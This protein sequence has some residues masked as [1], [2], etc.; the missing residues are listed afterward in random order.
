MHKLLTDFVRARC[1][2]HP[3]AH[4]ALADFVRAFRATIPAS[5]LESWRRDR[6]I[7]NLRRGGFA[8]GI[9]DRV[10]YVGGLSLNHQWRE[11]GGQLVS[12][13]A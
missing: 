9:I 7:E 4:V 12:V 8:V 1:V 10:Y 13:N 5:S 6:V 2:A 11:Q 3:A